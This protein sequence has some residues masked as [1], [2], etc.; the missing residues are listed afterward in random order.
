[1]KKNL[2]LLAIMAVTF[3]A[4][5]NANQV[6]QECD[7]PTNPTIQNGYT[8]EAGEFVPVVEYHEH[9]DTN[10]YQEF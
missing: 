3:A 8:N 4:G 10:K 6:D 9:L 2:I 5:C 1:M 7:L